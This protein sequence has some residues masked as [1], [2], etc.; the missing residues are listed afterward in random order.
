MREVGEERQGYWRVFQG[1]QLPPGAKGR[2]VVVTTPRVKFVS[3]K[4]IAEWP[5]FEG[6]ILPRVLCTLVLRGTAVL[7]SLL[8]VRFPFRG[9]KSSSPAAR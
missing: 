3:P 5:A 7:R 8:K 9:W 2:P 6:W 4:S 1:L